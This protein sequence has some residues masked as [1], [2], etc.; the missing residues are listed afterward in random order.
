MN[1][2]PKST[3]FHER[4]KIEVPLDVVYSENA[5]IVWR[6]RTKTEEVTICGGGFLLHRP[7]EPKRLVNLRM[8]LPKNF[9][10]YD[11]GKEKY[12]IWGLVR[13]VRLLDQEEP[14]QIRIKVGAALT[15]H[16]PPPSFLVDPTTVYDLK[17]ILRNQ[18]LWE[19]RELERHTGRYMRSHEERRRI[20]I[21]VILDVIGPDGRVIESV[22]GET[23]NI[24]E[25]G[26]ALTARFEAGFPLYIVVK[27]PGRRFR[28]LAKVRAIHPS[29]DDERFRLHLEFLSGKWIV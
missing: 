29:D 3:R 18:S 9:R 25:S 27:N 6:E 17:P 14:G 22:A 5:G 13:Y 26:M 12:E 23:H 8:P 11:F 16:R 2:V 20:E 24:S 7:L 28:Q 19:L 1:V 4:T 15:G 21:D 10:L